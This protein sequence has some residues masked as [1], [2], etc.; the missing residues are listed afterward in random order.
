MALIT[1]AEYARR[2][3]VT[4]GYI[5]KLVKKGVI[6]LEKG[7]VDPGQAD[8]AIAAASAPARAK[9][10]KNNK[11]TSTEGGFSKAQAAKEHYR[12]LLAKQE[13]EKKSGKLIDADETYRHLAGVFTVVKTR[14]RSIAPACAQEIAHLKM[15]KKNPREIVAAVEKILI[16]QHDEALKELSECKLP[17]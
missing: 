14:I 8:K 13:Y 6:V 16:K 15:G 2:K 11:P 4:K 10:R 5:N 7:K 17:E 1:Q 3:G 12:A 9:F